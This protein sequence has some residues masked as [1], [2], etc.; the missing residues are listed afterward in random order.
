[1][2]FPPLPA[3]TMQY[4]QPIERRHPYSDRR[5]IEMVLAMPQDLKWDREGRGG[6]STRFHHR[7][8]LSD[9]VPDEVVRAPSEV[10]FDEALHGSFLPE[11]QRVWLE[12][13]SAVHI[14]ERGLVEPDSFRAALARA[15][16]GDWY[17]S[18]LL[19][20]E[21]W[22]RALE[23]GGQMARLIPARAPSSSR[24]G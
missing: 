8:A 4:P 19:G 15:E 3:M 17:L 5:L 12:Q 2:C 16:Q 21:A 23:P 1:M 13:G 11:A 6:H 24:G 22:L 10:F 18:T 14:F 20:V 7:M 9:V